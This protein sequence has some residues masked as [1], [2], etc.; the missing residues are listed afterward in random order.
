MRARVLLGVVASLLGAGCG[1]EEHSLP[2]TSVVHDATETRR[3][4]AREGVVLELKSQA[5]GVVATFGDRHD[6]LEVDVF[7]DPQALRQ[8]GFD[9]VGYGSDCTRRNRRALRW[10]G[11]VRAIV[12]CDL[13]GDDGQWISRVERALSRL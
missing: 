3:V 8:T 9:D 11:N 13:T 5:P 1:G 6:V 12:N 7:G 4:F 10:K 2:Y